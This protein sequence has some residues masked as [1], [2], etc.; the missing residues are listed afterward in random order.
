MHNAL[1]KLLTNKSYQPENDF[2][3]RQK[4]SVEESN[5]V[6]VLSLRIII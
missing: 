2:Q 4:M 5:I 3:M 1:C 6:A